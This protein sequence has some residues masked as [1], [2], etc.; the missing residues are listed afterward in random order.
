MNEFETHL[1]DDLVQECGPELAT[2]RVSAP[3]K[4]RV[5]PAWLV[6]PTIAVAVAI[7]LLALVVLQI[8]STPTAPAA[9]AVSAHTDGT[10]T[11][12]IRDISGVTGAN[13]KL[14]DLRVR[15]RAVPTVSGCTAKPNIIAVNLA[16]MLNLPEHMTNGLPEHQMIV[17]QQVTLR[18]S[19]IPA[20]EML[21]LAATET[22]HG[23][24]REVG[25]DFFLIRGRVPACTR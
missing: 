3:P 19:A 2:V 14:S 7:G 17:R 5:K 8:S 10:V 22:G 21:I 16:P 18:P 1:W 25:L 4:V 23:A 6:A 20:G 9:Y 13:A 12:A 11:V 15:A 24:T